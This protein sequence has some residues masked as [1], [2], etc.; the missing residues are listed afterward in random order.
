M[1]TSGGKIIARKGAT[2]YA[3]AISVCHIC[4]CINA[5]ANAVLTLSTMLHGEYGLEDVCLSLPTILNADGIAGRVL[6][7]M[8]EEETEKLRRSA[9]TLRSV[10]DQVQI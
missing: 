5:N 2:F 6:P 3:I 9:E 1:R 4:E 7:T 10:I 8:T